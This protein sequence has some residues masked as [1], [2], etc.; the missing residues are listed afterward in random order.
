M[1]EETLLA[2]AHSAS[3]WLEAVAKILDRHEAFFLHICR[4]LLSM[5]HQDGTG[6]DS[7]V[8]RAINHPVGHVTQALLH[9][10]FRRRPEDAQGLPD[11][12]KP[13]FTS[14]CDIQIDQYRHGRVL[15]SAN[16]IALFR[17]DPDWATEYLLP[18]FN[19]QH[20]VVEAQAAWEGFLWSPRLYR[21]LL[22]AFK[23]DFLDTAQ[24]YADLGEHS[25][26]YPAILTYAALDPADSFSITEL[27]EATSVLPKEGL[28]EVVRTLVHSLEA[29]GDQREAH[30]ANRIQPYWQN[31]WPKSRHLASKGITEQLVRL[32]ISSRGAFPA[33][34]ATVH[35]WLQPVEHPNYLIHLLAKSELCSQYPQDALTLLNAIFADQ[36]SAPTALSDCLNAIARAW[37]DAHDDSRYPRLMEYARRHGQE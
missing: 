25:Q 30:W 1:P 11:N 24:H 23:K 19:W 33:A 8:T 3:W 4:R 16:V 20:S 13:I 31:I 35:D 37:P 15:L 6:T 18:L 9:Y 5:E 29:A 34:M 26:Q 14:L 12:L 10:W 2:I 17:V 7:P 32:A 27:H 21:P 28:A 36:P 22:A